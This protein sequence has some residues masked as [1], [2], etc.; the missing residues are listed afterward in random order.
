M[1]SERIGKSLNMLES[2]PRDQP[3]HLVNLHYLQKETL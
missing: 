1:T 2:V 3:V